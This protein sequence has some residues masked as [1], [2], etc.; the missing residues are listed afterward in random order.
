V[1]NCS[2]Q[3]DK[4]TWI[5][6]IHRHPYMKHPR[7]LRRH[8]RN[9]SKDGRKTRF[10]L[11]ILNNINPCNSMFADNMNASD[12]A[13]YEQSRFKVVISIFLSAVGLASLAYCSVFAG[14][15]HSASLNAQQMPND[16]KAEDSY[17]ALSSGYGTKQTRHATPCVPTML[18]FPSRLYRVRCFRFYPR[19]HSLH[20]RCNLRLPR[21]LRNRQRG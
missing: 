9:P 15:S 11:H 14:E 10:L 3:Q 12:R 1:L 21:V 13:F 19:L 2:F 16:S 20:V 17:T 8:F 18:W 7:S 5:V 4:Q 6:A